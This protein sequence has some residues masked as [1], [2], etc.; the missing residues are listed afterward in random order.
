MLAHLPEAVTADLDAAVAA[1]QR[2]WKSPGLSAGLVRGG[3]LVWSAHV[4]HARLD[5][6]TPPQDDTQYLM[7]SVTK[8]FVAVAVLRLRDEG[9]LGLRDRLGRFLP[10]TRH[11]ELQI[12]DL[13]SHSSGL[14][15]EPVGR[16][17]ESLSA[18]TREELIAGLEEAEAVLDPHRA[19][20]YSNLAY[21][22]LGDVVEKVTGQPWE[23]VVRERVLDPLGMG[24]TSTMPD[25]SRAAIGYHV[26]PYAG[27]AR[28]EPRI[29]LNATASLGGLW[30]SV[31]DLAR[32]AAFIADPDERVLRPDTLEEMCRPVIMRDDAWTGAHGLGFM[33]GR[34]GER[35]LVGHSGGMPGYVTGLRVHRPSGVGAVVFANSTSGSAPMA[36][37]GQLVTTVLDALPEPVE[38]WVPEDPN[39]AV[40]PLLGPWWSEGTEFVFEVREGRLWSRVVGSKADDARYEQVDDATWRVDE[41]RELGERLE[42]VFDETGAVARMYLATYAVTRDPRGFGDLL[43]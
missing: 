24:S 11:S 1:A 9:R 27:T 15:R 33:A 29:A 31:A 8:T 26:H 17:W 22:L 32:Y 14:Q 10:E 4:G 21:A 7:G 25:D 18:P 41:G 3:S 40:A 39:P 30:T 12:R 28:P 5:P 23:A 35:I 34:I 6:P 20:H 43:T 2:D 16:I 13:L 36:L 19:W 42:V 38:P 37:A